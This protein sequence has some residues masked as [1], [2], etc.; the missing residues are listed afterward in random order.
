VLEGEVNIIRNME[1]H[2]RVQNSDV[3]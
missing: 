1:N 3:S 2:T